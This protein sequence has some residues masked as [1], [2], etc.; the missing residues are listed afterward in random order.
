MR[1]SGDTVG[2]GV[3]YGGPCQ[4]V[5]RRTTGASWKGAAIQGGLESRSRRMA[6]VRSHYQGMAGEDTAGWK[7]CCGDL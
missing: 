7:R 5:I 6:I 2:K 1:N 4:E 3:F